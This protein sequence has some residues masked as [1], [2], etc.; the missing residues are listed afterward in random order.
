M[1]V[2]KLW[3]SGIGVS[4]QVPRAA[5][6]TAQQPVRFVIVDEALVC[7][8]PLQSALQL[9]PDVPQNAQR[10]DA[11]ARFHRHDRLFARADALLEIFV[12]AGAARHS[13][14]IALRGEI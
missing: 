8:V 3:S 6:G 14:A 13:A 11:V 4:S 12:M 9:E 7:R 1:P 2:K 5:A 10:G